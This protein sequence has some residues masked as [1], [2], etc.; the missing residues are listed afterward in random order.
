[1]GSACARK[2]EKMAKGLSSRAEVTGARAWP[3]APGRMIEGQDSNLVI[4][5]LEQLNM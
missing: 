5:V 2:K 1:M 3:R 4:K